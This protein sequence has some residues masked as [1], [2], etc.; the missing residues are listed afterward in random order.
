MKTSEKRVKKIV[1]GIL[2][3]LSK[4]TDDGH[5]AVALLVLSIDLLAENDGGHRK[6][7]LR[8]ASAVIQKVEHDSRHLC[9]GDDEVWH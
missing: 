6:C 3:E 8:H 4:V 7:L 2:K 9:H 5:E 1:Y